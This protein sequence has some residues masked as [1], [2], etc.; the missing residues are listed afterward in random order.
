MGDRR[1]AAWPALDLTIHDPDRIADDL[2]TVLHDGGMSGSVESDPHAWRVF[3][4]DGATRDRAA[5]ALAAAFAD[6]VTTRAIDVADE[7]WAQRS[8]TSLRAVEVGR[9]VV[10][11]PWDVP[12]PRPGAGI[13]IV[14]EPST[15]FGTGHHA[16]TRLCLLA[17]QNLDLA[18]S[19]VL[20]LGTGSGLLSVGAA[21]LGAASAVGIDWDVDAIAAA[22]E[23]VARNHV[24]H[25]VRLVCGDLRSVVDGQFDV[26]LANLTGALLI[27]SAQRIVGLVRPPG[28][29]AI[30]SGFTV[31]DEPAV[32]DA[33]SAVGVVRSHRTEEDW[34]ALTVGVPDPS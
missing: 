17:L 27:Q 10:A 19:R 16:S 11:P 24:S 1:R 2:L 34:V 7:P 5:L 18:G 14:I 26:V 32:R 12:E 20:D 28:G 25:I 15:G 9:V 3:Y 21:R 30:V 4:P 8:Q 6:A 33:M 13:V 23:N 31:Q 29:C 22:Q